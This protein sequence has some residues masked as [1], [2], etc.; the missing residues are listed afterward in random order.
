MNKQAEQARDRNLATRL[1]MAK[2]HPLGLRL[3]DTK[4]KRELEAIMGGR[5]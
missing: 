3:V 4:T 5:R 2:N 1:Q